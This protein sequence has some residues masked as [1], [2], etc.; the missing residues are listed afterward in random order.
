MA[1]K[2]RIPTFRVRFESYD[3]FLVEYGDH[4][5]K[6]L[7]VLPLSTELEPGQK[8]RIKLGLPDEE[9]LFLTGEIKAFSNDMLEV[10]NADG[11]I[12]ALSPYSPE[13]KKKLESC[14]EGAALQGA[15]QP[16]PG[17][18]TERALSLL[19]VDDSVAV[20]IE[21]GDA[22]RDKGVRVR[23]AENG[24]VGIAAAL[25]RP[26]DIILSDVE[27][28]VMD[29]WTFLRMARARRR[30]ADIPF[31]FFTR[32]TDDLSRLQGYRMGVED[33]LAK[34]MS[35]AEVLVRLEGVLAR[36]QRGARGAEVGTSLRGD[37][38]H[39]RLGSLLSFLETER[40]TG[41]LHLVNGQEEVIVKLE[42][43]LLVDCNDLHGFSRIQD[44]IFEL[45]DWTFGEFEFVAIEV[46]AAGKL[47][48]AQITYVLME[49]ARRADEAAQS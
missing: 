23:V 32:L 3:D 40:R 1:G 8:V 13:Q 28:P 18:E 31:V 29:G 47:D 33:Y 30:L 43:G 26:P 21:L 16:D 4:L 22:L 42:N 41:E 6:S 36:T 19:L 27:M 11:V 10:S 14:V 20:R 15:P 35:P 39:V 24:L 12:V 48:P 45:L 38:E 44:R 9:T 2:S 34:D 37:L 46:E 49:H 7:L 17:A 5:R 25:K